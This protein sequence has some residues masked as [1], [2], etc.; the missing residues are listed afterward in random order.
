M[1]HKF[2]Q[3][4]QSAITRLA[5][6]ACSECLPPCIIEGHQSR[7]KKLVGALGPHIKVGPQLSGNKLDVAAAPNFLQGIILDQTDHDFSI[8]HYEFAII[9]PVSRPV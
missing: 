4:F 7:F 9:V 8:I 6:D 1:T 5:M 2:K 3:R